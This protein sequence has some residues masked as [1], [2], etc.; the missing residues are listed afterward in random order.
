MDRPLPQLSAA[1]AFISATAFRSF[2]LHSAGK[3]TS[4]VAGAGGCNEATGTA[5]GTLSRSCS[6]AKSLEKTLLACMCEI[7]SQNFLF[8][9][10]SRD[11]LRTLRSVNISNLLTGIIK[12]KH[13]YVKLYG[14]LT[15][16]WRIITQR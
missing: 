14:H 5:H 6:V 2:S 7:F 1:A 11:G 9:V 10:F 12:P 13:T 4:W 8:A 15:A 16:K 3:G